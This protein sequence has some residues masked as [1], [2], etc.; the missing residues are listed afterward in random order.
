MTDGLKEKQAG[1]SVGEII[2]R[3]YGRTISNPSTGIMVRF[4]CGCL[5]FRLSDLVSVH[6]RDTF[7]SIRKQKRI[8]FLRA[9]RHGKIDILFSLEMY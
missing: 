5:L 2:D 4:M 1:N 7:K 8:Y 6:S 9:P 3:K